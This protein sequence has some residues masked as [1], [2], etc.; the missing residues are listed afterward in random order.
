MIGVKER[1]GV[2]EM[3]LSMIWSQVSTLEEAMEI[4]PPLTDL[5]SK[6]DSTDLEYQDVDNR[7][8]MLV[9]DSEDQRENMP[10]PPSIIQT[11][12]PHLAPILQE[13]IPIEEPA[14]VAPACHCDN[15]FST[16][17]VQLPTFSSFHFPLSSHDHTRT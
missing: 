1:I 4:D 12:T 11:T 15:S 6:E 5:T 8:V 3:L 2:L 16:F 13:L 10:P 14:P 9:G 7:N 17:S